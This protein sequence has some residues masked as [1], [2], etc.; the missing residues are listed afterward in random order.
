L[1]DDV[2]S[3]VFLGRLFD[4]QSNGHHSNSFADKP[5]NSLLSYSLDICYNGS[6]IS[7]PVE[8]LGRLDQTRSYSRKLLRQFYATS[9][10]QFTH[11]GPDTIKVLNVC[12]SWGSHD[13]E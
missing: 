2:L 6:V 8:E 13:C 10:K 9:G 12:C 3:A 5:V 1:D 7:V 11:H 4:D